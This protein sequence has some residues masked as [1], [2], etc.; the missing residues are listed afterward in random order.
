MSAVE[1][2]VR[3]SSHPWLMKS[4][5]KEIRDINIADG[6]TP[7]TLQTPEYYQELGRMRQ[8][9]EISLKQLYGDKDIDELT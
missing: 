9:L 3:P 4:H 1:Q 7:F 8:N 6:Q 5:L 2:A